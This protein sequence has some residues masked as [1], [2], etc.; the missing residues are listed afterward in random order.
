MTRCCCRSKTSKYTDLSDS[1]VGQ[2]RDVFGRFLREGFGLNLGDPHAV[3]RFEL[4]L[5]RLD[6]ALTQTLVSG[7]A[8]ERGRTSSPANLRRTAATCFAGTLNSSSRDGACCDRAFCFALACSDLTSSVLPLPLPLALPSCRGTVRGERFAAAAFSSFSVCACISTCSHIGKREM[9]SC[10]DKSISAADTGVIAGPD[11]MILLCG[12]HAIFRC[13]TSE[14]EKISAQHFILCFH[15][16][17]NYW[18][19]EGI[20][21][22]CIETMKPRKM[23]KVDLCHRFTTIHFESELFSTQA[24]PLRNRTGNGL[25]NSLAPAPEVLDNRYEVGDVSGDTT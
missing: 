5:V 12:D 16:R 18:Q 13:V 10:R 1:C 3:A 20:C 11:V 7:R 21:T 6:L 22:T 14:F 2:L 15:C 8:Q 25:G 19:D 4:D 24:L 23:Q 9:T 17:S